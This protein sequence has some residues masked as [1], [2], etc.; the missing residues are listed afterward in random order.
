[1]EWETF[2]ACSNCRTNWMKERETLA[3]PAMT[4]CKIWC[5]GNINQKG[6]GGGDDEWMGWDERDMDHAIQ[7]IHGWAASRYQ[8][9]KDL[10]E[11][12]GVRLSQCLVRWM[13]GVV[14]EKKAD[15]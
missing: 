2:K 1:M 5:E 7:C 12:G 10:K 4:S 14:G 6:G 13:G 9:K 3:T 8:K 15:G 11:K